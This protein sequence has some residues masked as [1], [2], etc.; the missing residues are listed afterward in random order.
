MR[1][2]LRRIAWFE[3]VW[4]LLWGGLLLVPARFAPP[5]LAPFLG[6]GRPWFILMLGLGWL[7]RWVAYGRLSRPTPI[8]IPLL[9]IL[10]WL[11]VNYWASTDKAMS[12]EALGY[13]LFGISLYAALLNWPPIHRHPEWIAWGLVLFGL[14][15]IV[16]AP[17]L[18]QLTSSK[19]FDTTFL[20]PWLQRL[21]ELTP[22]DVNL[23]R[24]GGALVVI[25]PLFLALGLRW[26][27]TRRRWL[28]PLML[29]VAGVSG[30]VL[31]LT[32]SR[33]AYMGAAVATTLLLVLRW[34]KLALMA[35]L[36][37]IGGV[38]V[39]SRGGTEIFFDQIG[40]GVDSTLYGLDGRMELW[41]RGIYALSDFALT[42]IGIGT[43]DRIIPLLYPTFLIAPGTPMGHAHNLLLQVGVDL[44]FPGLIAYLALVINVFVTLAQ[45]LRQRAQALPWTLAA[46]TAASLTAMFVHGLLDVPLWGTKPSFLPWLL[47]ALAMALGLHV[48]ATSSSSASAPDPSAAPA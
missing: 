47:V 45:V 2:I 36:L 46:G 17:F 22:G 25:Y 28:P 20:A 19:L 12:W 18:S 38:F 3:P 16:A 27:W 6:Q 8:D 23:N 1:L 42:G 43:F 21:A 34:R 31:L 11:P 33:G 15:M 24:L 26:D 39:F 40:V 5:N 29:L 41:S 48:R 44:G 10:L 30:L 37:L 14:G 9:L 13:L 35:P 4:V 7:L 32:Q